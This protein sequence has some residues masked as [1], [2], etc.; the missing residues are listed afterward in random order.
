MTPL[1]IA[2]ALGR[3]GYIGGSAEFLTLVLRHA[4]VFLRRQYLQ[5]CRVESGGADTRFLS[6]LLENK[7]VQRRAYYAREFVYHVT[8]KALYAAI[9]QPNSRLRRP[10]HDIVR[11]Q[12]LMTLDFVLAHP[13]H[14]YVITEDERVRLFTGPYG[15]PMEELPHQTYPASTPGTSDAVSYFVE[16]FPMFLTTGTPTVSFVFP[17]VTYSAGAHAFETF[18]ARYAALFAR[19]PA[20]EI[21]YVHAQDVEPEPAGRTFRQFVAPPRTAFLNSLHGYFT[22]RQRLAQRQALSM[23]AQ[24]HYARDQVRFRDVPELWFARWLLEGRAALNDLGAVGGSDESAFPNLHFR[25][26]LIPYIYAYHGSRSSA[27]RRSV[28]GDRLLRTHSTARSTSSS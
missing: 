9:G 8:S 7:H 23:S 25:P 2:T 26:L 6:R 16:R 4:G 14:Q 20:A 18:L 13:R 22:A 27:G 12:R 28:R 19:L 24:Q 15:V 3:Y 11:A 5:A 10:A 1:T 17:Q 21:L